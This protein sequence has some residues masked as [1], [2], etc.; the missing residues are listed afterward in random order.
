MNVHLVES[1]QAD[2]SDEFAA[3]KRSGEIVQKNAWKSKKPVTL[4]HFL[5]S[6]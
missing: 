6:F 1:A 5:V 3:D 4:Q 2:I